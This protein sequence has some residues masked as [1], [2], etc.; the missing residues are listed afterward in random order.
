MNMICRF[1]STLDIPAKKRTY[2]NIKTRVLKVGR[3][4]TFE[5]TARTDWIFNSLRHDP[6]LEIIDL[7][8]PW[9]GVKRK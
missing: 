8:F 2:E 3:F 1:D 5:P 7:G 9:T 6:E 4:S